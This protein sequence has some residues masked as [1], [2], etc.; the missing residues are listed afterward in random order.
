MFEQGR[1]FSFREL[2]P[3]GETV[4]PAG[5]CLSNDWGPK[6][7]EFSV[8]H[9]PSRCISYGELF[10]NDTECYP[11]KLVFHRRPKVMTFD[12]RIAINQNK[13][14]IIERQKVDEKL[15]TWKGIMGI[16]TYCYYPIHEQ[17]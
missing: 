17:E 3:E 9:T 2:V 1:E 7:S 13:T 10:D 15:I 11:S 6:Y 8:E 4:T 16:T 12:Y 14:Y 5:Q